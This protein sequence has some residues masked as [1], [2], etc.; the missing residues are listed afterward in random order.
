MLS[1]PIANG[2]PA[3]FKLPVIVAPAFVVVNFTLLLYLKFT[4]F[5]ANV[6]V[7]PPFEVSTSLT[8]LPSILKSPVPASLI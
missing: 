6:A 4:P 3:T 7:V 1:L 5:E 8:K 2:V